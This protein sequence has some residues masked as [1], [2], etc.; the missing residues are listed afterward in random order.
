MIIRMV[1]TITERLRID[2]TESEF[3]GYLLYINYLT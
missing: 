1:I 2:M 3:I